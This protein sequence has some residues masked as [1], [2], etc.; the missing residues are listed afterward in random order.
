M[1]ILTLLTVWISHE[2]V[3]EVFF[4]KLN[5]YLYSYVAFLIMLPFLRIIAQGSGAKTGL[6]FLMIAFLAYYTSGIK[7]PIGFAESFTNQLRLF[8]SDWASNCW[9]ILFPM[10]GFLITAH[11]NKYE[12]SFGKNRITGFLLLTSVFS[13]IF[14]VF[15]IHYDIVHNASANLEQIRQHMI[16]IPSC[17]LFYFVQKLDLHSIKPVLKT[18]LRTASAS[19]FG[20]FLLETHTDLSSRIFSFTLILSPCIG[21]F[22]CCIISIL[23]EFL[24][25]GSFIS[26][27]KL[28]PFLKKVL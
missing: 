25:Y 3:F 10:L 11:R 9:N 22:G 26:L 17:A 16:L 20:I 7:I 6:V 2:S 28:V 24:V 4:N 13:L 15:L 14:G 27:L 23:V 5:W 12:Q 8:S 21:R 18:I 19:T 1:L